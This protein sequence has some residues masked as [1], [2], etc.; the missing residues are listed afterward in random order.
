MKR[1]SVVRL[2]EQQR[3][4]LCLALLDENL[5]DSVEQY[6]GEIGVIPLLSAEEEYHL[7][8]RIRQG[9]EQAKRQFVEANLRLVV[10]IAKQY[11]MKGR[12]L[13]DMI[14][15]GNIGLIRAV[16]HFDHTKGFK[17]STYATW[18]IKQAIC[19]G[20]D[21]TARLVRLPVYLSVRSG[22]IA[23]IHARLFEQQGY[24]PTLEQIAAQ[25]GMD[26]SVVEQVQATNYQILSL[27]KPVSGHD[28]TTLGEL[29]PDERIPAY[30]DL[31]CQEED[32]RELP[33]Q[34]AAM[35]ACLTEREQQVII[36]H[37]GLFGVPC[38]RGYAEI[39][40]ELGICRERVRQVYARAIEKLRL[41][42]R[43]AMQ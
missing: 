15:D 35:L 31:L 6:L 12:N 18:W 14:Q 2:E 41:A 29:I 13:L 34:V 4:D 24:E 23:R 16:E 1:V 33:E 7:A 43:S 25:M 5:D 37:F 10:H 8:Q 19:R 11:S 39:G 38:H 3:P 36:L 20:L 9:D 40:R 27:D 32:E 42:A 17:F 30:D 22:M 28:D 21:N 26:V